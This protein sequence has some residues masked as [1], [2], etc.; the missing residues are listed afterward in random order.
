MELI[1][2]YEIAEAVQATLAVVAF[3]S[4]PTKAKVPSGLVKNAAKVSARALANLAR[5]AHADISLIKARKADIADAFYDIGEALVRLRARGVPEALGYPNF[6]TLCEREVGLRETQVGVLID[7]VTRLTREQA[8]AMGQS[9][10]AAFARLA[11]AT[12]TADTPAALYRRGVRTPSG[13]T[14]TKASS[15]R[16]IDEAS[17]EFRQAAHGS[18]RGRGRTTTPEERAVAA[19]IE[20]K[21]HAAGVKTAKVRALATVP[22][23]EA[24]LRIDGVPVSQRNRIAKALR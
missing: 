9:K 2:P 17:K 4:M 13:K 12:P 16:A 3:R 24:N 15:T 23:K 8:V 5:R 19:G 11:E 22:G 6:E 7:I 20:R 10:A 21:L 14:I 18:K 1:A